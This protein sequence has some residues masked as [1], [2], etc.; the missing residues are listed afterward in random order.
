MFLENWLNRQS[1][2][3]GSALSLENTLMEPLGSWQALASA[4]D[5]VKCQCWASRLWLTRHV[6]FGVLQSS[7][8]TQQDRHMKD[9]SKRVQMA[10]MAKLA[11]MAFLGVMAK[12]TKIAKKCCFL[13]PPKT[14]FQWRF[15]VRPQF[16]PIKKHVEECKFCF[17][18]PVGLKKIEI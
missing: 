12:M 9:S 6:L 3:R 17:W 14:V 5:V 18:P 11:K 8:V 4:Y 10:K 7:V 13:T 1:H 16:W 15:H 2:C